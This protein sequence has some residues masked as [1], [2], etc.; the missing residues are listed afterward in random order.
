[1]DTDAAIQKFQRRCDSITTQSSTRDI[2]I[3]EL[4]ETVR[5]KK[6][7]IHHITNYVTV[8][9]CANIT[10]AIGAAPV[11]AH[12]KEEVEEM[13]SISNALVL[14]I[15]T[16]DPAQIESML[17][18][19][20]KANQL[21]IPIILDPCGA[22]ATKLRTDSVKLLISSLKI[23]VIKGNT[24]EIGT[25]AGV[26]AE[27]HGVE[28]GAMLGSEEKAAESLAKKTGSTVIITGKTDIVTDGNKTYRIHNGSPMTGK[29]TGGGCMAASLVASFAAVEKDSA[30]AGTAALVC[31]GIAQE[32]AEK[33]SKGPLEFRKN[34]FDELY[35][36]T[37]DKIRKYERYENQN[38]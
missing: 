10:L 7:I 20:K 30:K 28:S 24:G 17:I 37:P 33:N 16:L 27:V 36:L 26:K 23:A 3:G 29:I 35:N 34:L 12:A 32:L 13:V 2:N 18:A 9:E 22:G 19:G 11:M 5:K 8:N 31:F 25:L 1:M 6:P 21:N 14:N 15:G 4:L 38:P